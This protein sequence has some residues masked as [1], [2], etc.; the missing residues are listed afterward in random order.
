MVSSLFLSLS[1]MGEDRC[2]C[3]STRTLTWLVKS[4]LP[5]PPAAATPLR[6]R[7]LPAPSLSSLPDDLLLECLS[8]VSLSSLPSLFLVSRRFSLLLS[9]PSFLL[10]RRSLGLLRRTL[11][12]F[13]LSGENLLILS[14]HGGA[15]WTQAALPLPAGGGSLP[16]LVPLGRS[17]FLLSRQTAA[18]YDPWTGAAAVTAP[19]LFPRKKFA[20]AAV[21][22]KIYVAGGSSK[23]SAVEEYDPLTD[24]W[25]VVAAA[26]RRRYGCVGAAAGGV[27]FIIGGLKLARNGEAGLD[28]YTCAGT[29]DLYDVRERKWTRAGAVPNGGCVVAA[30]AAGERIFVVASHAVE[31][32][33]WRWEWRG[34]RNGE[35]VRLESPHVPAAGRFSCAGIGENAVALVVDYCGGEKNI[36]VY[37]VVEGGWSGG[38]AMPSALW[39]L[40]CVCVEC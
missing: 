9:S 40:A 24:T 36:L 12:A 18:C 15:A 21:A 37:D 20:A 29:M 13:S 3:R 10:L 33:F 7:P 4:C 16:R 38:A 11:F 23:T 35:W 5:D 1:S 14:S 39:R 6:R 8:R 27:F 32:S 30:C 25:Q 26:P 31:I 28:A 17:I 22:G 34:K 19:T 2:S